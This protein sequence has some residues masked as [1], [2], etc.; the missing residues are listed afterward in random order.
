MAADRNCVLTASKVASQK[1]LMDESEIGL[2]GKL[3]QSAGQLEFFVVFP[4]ELRS[5]NPCR[6]RVFH[7]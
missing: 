3:L 1:V 5:E 4:Y 7:I 6:N 2:F